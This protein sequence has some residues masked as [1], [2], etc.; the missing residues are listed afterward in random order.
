MQKTEVYQIGEI[1]RIVPY[2]GTE[3]KEHWNVSQTILGL[4]VVKMVQQDTYYPVS[5]ELKLSS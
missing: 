5:T 3:N 1:I 2:P 4:C